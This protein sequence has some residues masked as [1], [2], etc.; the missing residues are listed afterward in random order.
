MFR[1]FWKLAK[2]SDESFQKEFNREFNVMS[3]SII[4][5]A[6]NNNINDVSYVEYFLFISIIF[7]NQISFETEAN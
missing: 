5:T 3:S 1:S 7:D 6:E 2:E 4:K